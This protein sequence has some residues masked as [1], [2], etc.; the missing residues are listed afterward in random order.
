MWHTGAEEPV[1]AGKS[2][3]W[4][5]SEGAKSS[6]WSAGQLEGKEDTD[7]TN[8]PFDIPRYQY[9][10]AF[11]EVRENKGAAGADGIT[12]ADYEGNLE[13]NLYKLWNRMSSGTYF[14]KPV[15]QV[16]IPKKNGKMRPLGIPT[17]EDR[18]AQT[19]VKNTIEPALEEIF[20]E[21]SFGYRPNRSP[22]DAL[23]KARQRCW[24]YDWVIEFDI[25]GLFDNIDHELLFKAVDLRVEENWARL[26][27]RRWS[28]AALVDEEGTEHERTSGVS[29]GGVTSPLMA[30][31]FMHYAFDTWM[32][33]TYP[34]CPFERFADDAII[35]CASEAEAKAVLRALDA[36]M[37]ECRLELHP[38]K[39]R[40]VYC[41]DGNRRG[42]YENTSFDFLGYTFRARAARNTRTG[43][44]F[45]NFLPAVSKASI[46]R[47]LDKVRDLRLRKVT[48]KD[49][50]I[51][52]GLLNPILRGW[53]NYFKAF[54]PSEMA[55]ALRLV[56]NM[57]K[58]WVMRKYKGIHNLKHA[59]KWLRGVM[60][61]EPAL[62]YH[63]SQGFVM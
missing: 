18:V 11:E 10:E 35:H 2:L 60:A 62:F 49:I 52:A 55:K 48:Q 23:A 30:N 37:T 4:G 21:D 56:N 24:E 7:M 46:K 47:L 5:W 28:T 33:R 32:R 57:L 51:I 36:R 1:V 13:G 50:G 14:P 31:L 9:L 15:K 12:I 59:D 42:G 26:Y 61:R 63:W 16:L 29:Q 34:T 8:K 27:L 43:E 54:Y 20:D 53:M 38:E 39:T 3:Q 44:I 22:L 45:T 17:V 58:R 19:V 6:R 41:K 25:V 40:I